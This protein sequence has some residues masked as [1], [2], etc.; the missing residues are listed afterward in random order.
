MKNK[1]MISDN[2]KQLTKIFRSVLDNDEL[3]LNESMN[4]NDIEGWDSLGHVRLIMSI[5]KNFKIR[6]TGEEISNLENIGKIINLIYIK[7]N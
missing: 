2:L 7:Q 3:T 1:L 4:L 6:F 5:E